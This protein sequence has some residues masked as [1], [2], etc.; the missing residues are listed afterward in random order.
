MYCSDESERDDEMHEYDE[1][2]EDVS[3]REGIASNSGQL[4]KEQRATLLRYITPAALCRY[5]KDIP[6]SFSVAIYLFV[7]SLE[8]FV[9]DCHA[10][11]VRIVK[12]VNKWENCYLQ[13]GGCGRSQGCVS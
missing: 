10:C 4:W 11:L 2:D 9:P 12:C 13:G 1:D 8:Y 3:D 7:T 5:T 6:L